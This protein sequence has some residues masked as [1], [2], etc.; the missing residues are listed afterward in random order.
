MLR[1]QACRVGTSAVTLAHMGSCGNITAIRESCPVD[2]NRL[3]VGVAQ[4]VIII[5]IISLSRSVFCSAPQDGPVC[6]S[7]GNVYN[8]TCQMKL[9][10][11][12]QGVVCGQRTGA[13]Q[14][15]NQFPFFLLPSGAH[16]SKAL[17]NHADLPGVLLESCPPYVWL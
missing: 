12:G 15:A 11:C 2:C 4:I 6:A 10:T 3:A 8:S 14:L 13:L 16:Q 1:V 5:I 17:P 9:L 7:D